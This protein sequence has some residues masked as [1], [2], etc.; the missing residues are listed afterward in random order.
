MILGLHWG[1]WGY[2]GVI[3]GLLGLHWGYIGVILGL[4]WGYI[5][6]TL[7]LYWGYIGLH[8]GYI[9]VILGLHW[10]Y[11]GVI[12][13]KPACSP[14]Q[15]LPCPTIAR[16]RAFRTRCPFWTGPYAA[17]CDNAFSFQGNA[18]PNAQ[19]FCQLGKLAAE[20]ETF[21]KTSCS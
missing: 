2:I 17:N 4:H 3:L 16:N 11:I 1:Y 12:M 10:G 9:G 6:V 14:Y 18:M 19:D 15:A 8:W 13:P 5:G 20:T 7:G 21:Q